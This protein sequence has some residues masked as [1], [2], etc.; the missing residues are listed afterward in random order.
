MAHIRLSAQTAQLVSPACVERELEG[1]AEYVL[2]KSSTW[3]MWCLCRW[4]GHKYK[5]ELPE[6]A[7]ELK[8]FLYVANYYGLFVPGFSYIASMFKSLVAKLTH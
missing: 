1:Q 5:P 3:A 7:K 4:G 6:N 8:L 2:C